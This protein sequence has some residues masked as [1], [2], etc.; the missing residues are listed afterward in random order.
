MHALMIFVFFNSLSCFSLGN[1]VCKEIDL[2]NEDE[3][4][5]TSFKIHNTPPRKD[6]FETT[7]FNEQV[8]RM[9]KECQNREL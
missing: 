7:V 9:L 6:S 5:N 3:S 1:G 2:L 4:H 8:I